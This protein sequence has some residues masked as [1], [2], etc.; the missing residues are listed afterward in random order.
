[1]TVIF[2]SF[3]AIMKGASKVKSPIHSNRL[4]NKYTENNNNIR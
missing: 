3:F 1:M 4:Y 2:Y